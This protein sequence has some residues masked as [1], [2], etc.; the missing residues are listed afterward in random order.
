MLRDCGHRCPGTRGIQLTLP[1]HTSKVSDGCQSGKTSAGAFSYVR[2]LPVSFCQIYGFGQKRNMVFQNEY[3]V[4]SR[5]D[6]QRHRAFLALCSCKKVLPMPMHLQ[7]RQLNVNANQYKMITFYRFIPFSRGNCL[8]IMMQSDINR[9]GL[10]V[11]NELFL[12]LIF[13]K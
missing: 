2:N 8:L 1:F 11:S 4:R 6:G 13:S 10:H 3:Y 9:L 5:K 7:H 12:C